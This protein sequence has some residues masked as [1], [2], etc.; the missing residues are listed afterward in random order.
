MSTTIRTDLDDKPVVDG[1][2]R[3]AAAAT[4][5]TATIQKTAESSASKS[6]NAWVKYTDSTYK[7][8][9]TSAEGLGFISSALGRINPQLAL[10][11]EQTVKQL[12]TLMAWG[13]SL[14]KFGLVGG[15]LGTIGAS[16][17]SIA[18][19]F[20]KLRNETVEAEGALGKY[21]SLLDSM[22]LG[23]AAGKQVGAI[24][25]ELDRQRNPPKWT[26]DEARSG[27]M[28][29]TRGDAV[30]NAIA[31]QAKIKDY[32]SGIDNVDSTEKINAMLAA[33][34]KRIKG[35]E[36]L[37]HLTVEEADA[38]QAYQEGLI[39]RYD[40]LN[41]RID[42]LRQLEKDFATEDKNRSV[43]DIKTKENANA[44]IAKQIGLYRQLYNTDQLTGDKQKEIL[45]T[46]NAL[47]SKK[48][49]LL[50]EER[51]KREA[52]DAAMRKEEAQED[53]RNR[54][55]GRGLVDQLRGGAGGG[56]GDGVDRGAGI[57][58][59]IVGAVD[60]NRIQRQAR[61][62][63]MIVMRQKIDELDE[64][65]DQEIADIRAK[66][67]S[68]ELGGREGADLRRQALKDRNQGRLAAKAQ[69]KSDEKTI[70]QRETAN[71]ANKVVDALEARGDLDAK[72]AEAVRQLAKAAIDDKARIENLEADFD[73]IIA[74][75]G[76][77]NKAGR[78]QRAGQR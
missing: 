34:E 2:K 8:S 62:A 75:M 55:A 44:L 73:R 26:M 72:Q 57:G 78:N 67:A 14:A 47:Q 76:A 3:I 5:T 29:K 10:V 50:E 58:N 52:L 56:G 53:R 65:F 54:N 69:E 13:T 37:H 24:A 70:A 20:R 63:A 43:A 21:I 7:A 36:Q 45:T 32:T 60:K 46:I 68:G 12:P 4:S 16:A 77:A 66:V 61:N 42:D 48:N 49:S 35:L 31:Q 74:A 51:Q 25:D 18:G 9:R 23:G 30:R 38:S 33:E 15:A 22:R 17:I 28:D 40:V 39:A 71:A 6:A 1:F 59:Q 11:G 41:S 27:D 19:N 64:A